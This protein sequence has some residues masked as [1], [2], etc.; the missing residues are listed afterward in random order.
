MSRDI[1]LIHVPWDTKLL[2]ISML[3][4][5]FV[6]NDR[7]TPHTGTVQYIARHTLDAKTALRL[8]TALYDIR[9]ALADVGYLLADIPGL[10]GD[11]TPESLR[12]FVVTVGSN[13]VIGYEF[14]DVIHNDLEDPVIMTAAELIRDLFIAA[15]EGVLTDAPDATQVVHS[16]KRYS[17]V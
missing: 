8:T 10:D 4:G 7:V 3:G 11:K 15:I 13:G 17:S 16:T 12:N 1:E 9:D 14:P 2:G 5:L 6:L